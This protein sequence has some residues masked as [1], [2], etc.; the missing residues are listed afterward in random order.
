MEPVDSRTPRRGYKRQERGWLGQRL[1]EMHYDSGTNDPGCSW[2][3]QKSF[4]SLFRHSIHPY[5]LTEHLHADTRL[6]EA[7]KAIQRPP[8]RIVMV[9]IVVTPNEDTSPA[10]SH[11]ARGH[12]PDPAYRQANML[13]FFVRIFLRP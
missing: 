3:I 2:S 11:A 12:E 10:H 7:T 8:I 9:A 1:S 13:T 6:Q 5:Y 4:S